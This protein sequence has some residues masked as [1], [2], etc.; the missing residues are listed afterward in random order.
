MS[1]DALTDLAKAAGLALT[2]TDTYG[3]AKTVPLDTLRIVLN[4]LGLPANSAADIADSR[5]RL[6]AQKTPPLLVAR[7]GERLA[8]GPTRRAV[9][10]FEDGTTAVPDLDFDHDGAFMTVP[11][12]PGYHRI[13]TDNGVRELAIAPRCITVE[14][15]ARGRRLT[16]L[17]VQ[18]YSLGG[19]HSAGFGDLAALAD[20]AERSASFGVDAVAV[21]PLHALFL[22]LPED[23]SPY[24]PSTRLF[25]NP[26]YAD[27]ALVGGDGA[28]EAHAGAFVD[29]PQAS[30]SKLTALRAAFAQFT[31]SQPPDDFRS[32]CTE[33]GDRLVWHARFE[34]LDAHFRSHGLTSWQDW[35]KPFQHVAS[36]EVEAF[37]REHAAAVDFHIFLQWLTA[38]SL[39]AAHKRACAAGMAIGLISDIAVGMDPRGS[40]AWC[41]PGEILTG[42]SVGAPPDLLNQ[43]GQNW[44]LTALSPTGLKDGGYAGF[45][46]TL[47][48]SM[49]HAGGVRIDHAMGLCRL[50]L[51]PDGASVAE[52]AYLHYPMHDLLNLIALESRRNRAI[53]IGEDL[54]TVP[55]GFR[56]AMLRAGM[57]GMEVLWFQREGERFLTLDRWHTHNAALSTTHDLPTIAGWWTGRDIEWQEKLG[58]ISGQDAVLAECNA[59]AGDRPQLWSAL[60]QAG[61]AKTPQPAPDD[62]APAV[63]A[64]LDFVGRTPCELAIVPIEDVLALTEQPNIPGTVYEH[65]NWQRRLPPGDLFGS[66][67]AQKNLAALRRGRAGS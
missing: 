25:L 35:P 40:H 20:F 15:V 28:I 11:P 19:G 30:R 51:V 47:R 31:T 55:E 52:G 64:A 57:M 12:L 62:P 39:G 6:S 2:W 32:F 53:V 49:R 24:S 5:Q 58:R 43:Q 42:L 63:E 23:I 22:A 61:S 1:E 50:W 16:G 45:I 54:G 10:Y 34:A 46:A 27:A 13:E 14:D 33:Q 17:A 66:P 7:I 8:L 26:L 41:S 56:E 21:S 18:L 37:T 38:K 3:N 29:W 67:T 36:P 65:P 48:A 4:A 59:R 60:Q 9:I 44:G